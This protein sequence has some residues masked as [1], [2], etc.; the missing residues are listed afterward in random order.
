M[1]QMVLA[2]G[3]LVAQGAYAAT[4]NVPADY[5]SIQLAYDNAASG[6]TIVVAPGTYTQNPNFALGKTVT[7]TGAGIGLTTVRPFSLLGCTTFKVDSIFRVAATDN[8]SLSDMTIDGSNCARAAE[9]DGGVLN[10]RDIDVINTGAYVNISS[11]DYGGS[12]YV[13]NSGTLELSGS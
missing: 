4:I 11:N 13:W 9:V 12:F 6:D 1:R 10:L 3:L 2:S 8:I 7:I 5:T